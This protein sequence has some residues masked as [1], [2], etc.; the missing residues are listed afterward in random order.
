[1]QAELPTSGTT[2]VAQQSGLSRDARA[3]M[4]YEANKKTALVAYILWF[5]LGLLG[6]HN[7][8]LKRTGVAVA[9]LILTL[10][11]VGML[12]TVIWVLVD[13]FLIPGWVR[14]QNN[15]LAAQLGA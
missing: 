6:G 1:M 15:I 10:T 2:N 13:A 8:Y 3:M 7:F 11:I 4:L 12:I 14:N 9:Q 5:F